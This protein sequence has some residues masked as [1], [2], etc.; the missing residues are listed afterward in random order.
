LIKFHR[1]EVSSSFPAGDEEDR[2]DMFPELV[3]ED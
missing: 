1:S 3:G 2:D